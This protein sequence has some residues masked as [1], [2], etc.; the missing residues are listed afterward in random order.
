MTATFP[1]KFYIGTSGWSYD[2]W[3]GVV[4]PAEKHRGFSELAYLAEFFDAV[5]VNT[6]FYRPPSPSYCRKWLRDVESNERF[7]FT[8]KLWQR[9]THEREERWS[10]WDVEVFK[11]GIEPIADA[12]RLGALLVQF[13]WSFAATD[14]NLEWLQS[15]ADAF[16]DYP[17]VV[18]VRHISW[19]SKECLEFFRAN[20]LNFCNIDQPHTRNSIGHTNIAT[21]S[22]AY[23]RFH[24]RNYK[25][26]F[27]RDAGR[28]ERYNYLYSERELSPW[29]RDMEEMEKRIEQ[30][31][32]M[33]NNHYRGQAPVNALQIK[34]AL[35]GRKVK[36]PPTLIEHYPI[37]KRISK[38][39]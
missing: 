28:D 36:V 8:M 15:I 14:A 12:G 31:Y 17:L 26:W 38:G 11:T 19:L 39:E 20:N 25:A 18:E 27:S 6:S 24:G 37:L 33:T 3:K 35:T 7:R 10:E 16:R 5:E 23:Y 1:E 21:G 9:F 2:D 4:Y 13:P 22:I 34:A 30:I 29:I 32:V